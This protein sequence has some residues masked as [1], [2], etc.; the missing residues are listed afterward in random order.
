M[1]GLLRTYFLSVYSFC[2]VPKHKAVLTDFFSSKLYF[3]LV[4]Y[5]QYVIF[6]AAFK[7]GFKNLSFG[8][9]I[10]NIH[11]RYLQVS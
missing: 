5:K 9:F 3:S 10:Q 1:R 4:F 2:M 7:K 11:S 8:V 6:T